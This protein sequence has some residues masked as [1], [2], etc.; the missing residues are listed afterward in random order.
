M[1]G[2]YAVCRLDP[3]DPLPSWVLQGT[4]FSVT[5]TLAELSVVCESAL[6]PAGVQAES[7]WRTL[8]VKGPLDFA[9][10]GI[11]ARLSTV[12]AGAAV[13]VFVV[14]TYNTDYI[15]VREA[16][17]DNALTALQNAGHPVERLT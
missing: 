3:D 9:L 15:L 14:S 8:A 7:G 1:P 16:Q 10:T 5:R 11:M 6:V 12:L 17:L 13:S 4:F 2:R